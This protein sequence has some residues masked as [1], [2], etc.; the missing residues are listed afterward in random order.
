MCLCVFKKFCYLDSTIDIKAFGN[1]FFDHEGVV[2]A[3]RHLLLMKFMFKLA[4]CK[5]QVLVATSIK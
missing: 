2:D 1:H 4:K 3:E 5:D